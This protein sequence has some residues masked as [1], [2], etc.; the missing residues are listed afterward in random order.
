MILQ[1]NL[2]LL[3]Q[4]CRQL[5][6][7]PSRKWLLP[8][9]NTVTIA[10][11]LE[12]VFSPLQMEENHTYAKMGHGWRI[13]LWDKKSHVHM[14]NLLLGR[15]EYWMST[16]KLLIQTLGCSWMFPVLVPTWT[17][18][19]FSTKSGKLP[20]KEPCMINHPILTEYNSLE[21]FQPAVTLTPLESL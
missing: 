16:S 5:C 12:T 7:W 21:I 15:S 4:F 10:V 8:P 6:C 13:C 2:K 14:P 18:K 9:R 19:I 3:L 20:W 11:F 17:W 1:K